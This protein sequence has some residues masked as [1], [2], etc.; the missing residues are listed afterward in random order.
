MRSALRLVK[1]TKKAGV[2]R[3]GPPSE[4]PVALFP[5]HEGQP[6]AFKVVVSLARSFVTEAEPE[7]AAEE[8]EQ[9][10]ERLAGSAAKMAPFP[11]TTV[12]FVKTVEP[13][14]EMDA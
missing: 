3:V 13:S 1:R 8:P 4:P 11:P 6:E 7:K 5:V 9:V 10:I 2:E 14:I 12:L